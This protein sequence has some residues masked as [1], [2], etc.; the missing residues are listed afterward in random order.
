MIFSSWSA[1]I[2]I[3]KQTPL[4]LIDGIYEIIGISREE[5]RL[6]QSRKFYENI[7]TANS[8]EQK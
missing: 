6:R 5:M 3:G 8:S 2:S 1:E 7:M 4:I